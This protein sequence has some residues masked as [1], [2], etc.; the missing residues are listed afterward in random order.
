VLDV[1]RPSIAPV[2]EISQP[3]SGGPYRS[4]VDRMLEGFR[5][6]PDRVVVRDASRG[7]TGGDFA[8][9]IDGYAWA[10]AARGLGAGDRVALLATESPEALAVRYAVAL[11]GAASVF[12]PDTGRPEQL[13]RF[14]KQIRPR[15]L[16]VFPETAPD[17]QA[18]AARILSDETV[19]VGPV[20]GLADLAEEA[21]AQDDMP[22][23]GRA[24]PDDLAVLIASGGTTGGSKASMRSFDA[25]AAL[26]GDVREP[27]RK[28]L[29]CSAFAYVSQVLVAQTL[30]GGG[31]V[32]LRDRFDP[33][34]LLR[35]IEA[36]GITQL[37]L[38]EPLLAEFADHP[39]LPE[40]DLSTLRRVSHI[41]AVA[42]AS[43]RRRLLTRFGPILVNTY[44]ASEA[45]MVSLLTAPDYSLDH[46]ERLST[47]GRP[48]PGVDVRLV[49]VD[50]TVLPDHEQGV[51]EV[52]LRGM[53]SGY[54]GRPGDPAFHDGW[55]T[56]GD[57]GFLDRD[58]YL[59]VRGRAA[60]ARDIDG[61][62]VLP[63]DLE[64]AACAHP[65]VVYAVALPA[66][67]GPNGSFGV[68]AL[69]AHGSSV[70][71]ADVRAH[72]KRQVDPPAAV[73][74]VVLVDHLPVTEQGKP[75]RSIIGELLRR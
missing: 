58:G 51:I 9:T 42:P 61:V 31:S 72:L 23:V 1:N 18:A 40:Y 32:T 45:G 5:A 74:D 46:P 25:Y 16:V 12:T 60:D 66:T 55:Y 56:T 73:G 59:H 21:A 36:E 8:G 30:L 15:L 7:L 24:Q 28:L 68:L 63:L 69:R 35:V 62:P 14:L 64:E 22:F 2:G 49:A 48:R 71:A 41:G 17:A 39:D 65:E 4:W 53:S 34:E 19:S 47:A 38:V 11:V 10:L 57:L 52:R 37:S 27:D 43:F 75:D 54:I 29:V 6:D 33:A 13:V 3:P 26:V 70:E 44:G 20:D 50:G 67:P